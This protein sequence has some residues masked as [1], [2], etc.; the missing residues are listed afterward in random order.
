MANPTC[1]CWSSAEQRLQPNRADQGVG[2]QKTRYLPVLCRAPRLL[3]RQPDDPR[4]TRLGTPVP[5]RR[6]AVREAIIHRM[7]SS[8][9]AQ[10]V[11]RDWTHQR[12]RYS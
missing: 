12:P 1:G 10:S 11:T 9:A 8:L 4:M 2:V 7:I 6:R 3:P 5:P